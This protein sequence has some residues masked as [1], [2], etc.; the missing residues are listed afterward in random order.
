MATNQK[1]I[2]KEIDQL[3]PISL[4]D[5]REYWDRQKI[6]IGKLQTDDLIDIYNIIQEELKT[7]GIL[8]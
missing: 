5:E 4:S 6:I 1:Q 2:D 7:R 8:R 3:Y